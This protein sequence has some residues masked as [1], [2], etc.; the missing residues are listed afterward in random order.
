MQ[1][2]PSPRPRLLCPEVGLS[3]LIS[4]PGCP[5]IFSVWDAFPPDL[6][7]KLL[8]QV[9]TKCPLLR[10]PSPWGQKLYSSPPLSP[11]SVG[12]SQT[13][14][15]L[16]VLGLLLPQGLCSGCSLRLEDCPLNVHLPLSIPCIPSSL[17]LFCSLH[18]KQQHPQCS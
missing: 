2:R 14:C 6:L 17:R 8:P 4:R 18:Q 11:P 12:S 13:H 16:N 9:L 5:F 7:W 3:S 15:S 1:A 10:E